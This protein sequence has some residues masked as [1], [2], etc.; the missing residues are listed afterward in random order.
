M[1]IAPPLPPFAVLL[2]KVEEITVTSPP[3]TA[4]PLEASFLA[5]SE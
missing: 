3:K 2:L 5:K 4:P 1:F